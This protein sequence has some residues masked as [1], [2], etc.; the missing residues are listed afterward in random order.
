MTSLIKS[1][2]P[3]VEGEPVTLGFQ[4]LPLALL[5][6]LSSFIGEGSI[7]WH[8]H[9]FFFSLI[10]VMGSISRV[11]FGEMPKQKSSEA[12]SR[13][14]SVRQLITK[15][16]PRLSRWASGEGG[17]M[18]DFKEPLIRIQAWPASIFSTRHERVFL[19][20]PFCFIPNRTMLSHLAFPFYLSSTTNLFSLGQIFWE[21]TIRE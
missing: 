6:V 10:L 13:L 19:S 3:L 5:P 15:E 16:G 7:S 1:D 20:E 11:S 14:P 12:S 18:A 4:V 2:A 9:I 21:A 8:G 17:H